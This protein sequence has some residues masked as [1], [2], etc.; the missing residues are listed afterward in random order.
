MRIGW[1][2]V[3]ALAACGGKDDPGPSCDQLTDHLLSIMTGTVPGHAGMAMAPRQLMI[4]RCDEKHY[5]PQIRTCMMAATTMAAAGA[6]S[7]EKPLVQPHQPQ[8]LD[9][10]PAG[11][12]S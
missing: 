5:A 12:G 7:G 9:L 11:S 10:K 6:C 4:Q 8:H 1:I 3:A 2:V